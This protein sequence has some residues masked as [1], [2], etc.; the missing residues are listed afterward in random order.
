MSTLKISS[1]VGLIQPLDKCLIRCDTGLATVRGGLYGWTRNGGKKFHGGVDLYA[2]KGT[3]CYAIYNGVV[4]WAFKT[5]GDWGLAV[6][7]RV[8]LP[9]RTCWVLYAHL[10]KVAV[11]SGTKLQQKTVIGET[12]L[13]GNA[14]SKYPHLHFETWSSLKAG[15]RSNDPGKYRFDPLLLLGHVSFEDFIFKIMTHSSTA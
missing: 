13:S 1:A 11:K 14:D 6:L 9:E 10:S 15:P 2:E 4:E 8:N 3:T 5:K 12:G 7:A